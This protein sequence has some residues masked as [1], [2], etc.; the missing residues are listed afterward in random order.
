MPPQ[1]R[2]SLVRALLKQL[3]EPSS[4]AVIVVRPDRTAPA[5]IRTNGHRA[6]PSKPA[7]DPSVVFILE[8]ATIMATRDHD[9]VALIGQAVADALQTVVRD[10]TNVHPLILARAVYYLLYLLNESQVSPHLGLQRISLNVSK[11][12]SFVRAPIILHTIAGYDQSTLE[13]A[14]M[15]ILNGLTLCI[16]DPSPLRNEVTNTPDFWSIIRS[17]HALPEAAGT[18]FALVARLVAGQQA[19]VT[20]DNYKDTVS[21]LNGFAAAGSVG[22]VLEQKRDKTARR[23]EKPTKPV[24]PR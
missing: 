5:P 18:A 6:N 13:K 22:A 8:M 12:H 4:P 24:K 9:A 16:R 23:K 1:S 21:L 15:P 14:S 10:A 20:A 19:A 7:Y 2:Q 17:L 3:P 11:D